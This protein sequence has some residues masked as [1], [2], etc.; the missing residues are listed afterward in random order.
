MHLP[1]FSTLITNFKD[2]HFRDEEEFAA[3]YRASQQN[4]S[5][6][7]S[8]PPPSPKF[9]LIIAQH[10]HDRASPWNLNL[11]LLAHLFNH[12]IHVITLHDNLAPQQERAS[13]QGN[14]FKPTSKFGRYR[15]DY[16]WLIPSLKFFSPSTLLSRSLRPLHYHELESWEGAISSQYSSDLQ[17]L[18]YALLSFW[19]APH[20]LHS[21]PHLTP[22]DSRS[23]EG[24]IGGLIKLNHSSTWTVPPHD[25]LSHTMQESF[26]TNSVFPPS[27]PLDFRTPMSL[28]LF[29][30]L[31]AAWLNEVV[32]RAVAL[33]SALTKSST[34]IL[35]GFEVATVQAKY[36]HR[37]RPAVSQRVPLS[38][39]ASPIASSDKPTN[40]GT[41]QRL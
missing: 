2:A 31:M 34:C 18:L 7:I 28:R 11:V 32:V 3:H 20:F 30:C 9:V 40:V 16:E 24:S 15:H 13:A 27:A 38:V 33:L 19:G 10:L 22:L 14:A 37:I 41:I 25:P 39:L 1:T 36:E 5:G 8:T 35:F 21:P 12:G 29:F 4:T 23:C 6:R 17:D 26:Y